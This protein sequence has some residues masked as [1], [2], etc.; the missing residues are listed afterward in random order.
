MKRWNHIWD[1][2]SS[3]HLDHIF[4][5]VILQP[6]P[7]VTFSLHVISVFAEFNGFYF[8][9]QLIL[10]SCHN[11]LV[12]SLKKLKEMLKSQF[13]GK[14]YSVACRWKYSYKHIKFVVLHPYWLC[15][16]DWFCPQKCYQA[17][18][19]GYS[20]SPT[21]TSYISQGRDVHCQPNGMWTGS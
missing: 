17:Q 1:D 21:D 13:L 18:F 7:Q 9:Q 2:C 20:G 19:S 16:L 15:L 3:P 10:C 12:C 11:G 14:K 5:P 6:P 8:I 4:N